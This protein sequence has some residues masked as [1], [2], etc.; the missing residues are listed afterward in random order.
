MQAIFVTGAASG[1][2]RATATLFAK[3]GW[4]VG[5]ADRNEAGL[6]EVAASLGGPHST[7]V[8]DVRDIGAWESELASFMIAGGRLDVLFNNA[9][10]AAGGPFG[11]IDIDALDRVIDINF[12]GLVYGARVA[13]PH[14]KATPGSC[15]LNT[16]SASGIY[17]SAGLA[18][19]S[20]TKFAV[21]GLTEALDGEWAA[22]GIKVRAIMPSFIDTPLL[23]AMV[24]KGTARERVRAQGLEFTPVETVAQ[25][26][27]D[28]V[29]GDRVLT[30]VGRTAR[31]MMFAARWMPG[32]LR[33]QMRGGR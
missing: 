3:A 14:L 8:M 29:H 25:A 32:K 5:L 21:R 18:T 28:A 11:A 6:A 12:R 33:R 4:R 15:L 7:H 19:Y 16:S 26:A 1:I 17:G 2:G 24:G 22:D 13:Y 30:P 10:I 9:G 31:R 23:D 20:A 27:W